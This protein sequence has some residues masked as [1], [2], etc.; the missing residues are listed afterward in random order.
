MRPIW[1]TESLPDW[2]VYWLIPMLSAGQSWPKASESGLW[3][4]REAHRGGLDAYAG[5]FEPTGQALSTISPQWESPAKRPAFTRVGKMYDENV[6]AMS[7]MASRYQY[8]RQA[9]AFA[10]ET[11]YSKISINVAFWVAVIAIAIA[12][13]SAFFSAGTS[14]AAVGPAAAGLRATIAK[15][16]SRLGLAAARPAGVAAAARLTTLAGTS[17]ATRLGSAAVVHELVEEIG[18]EVFIDAYTQYQQI[19]MGTGRAG[20]GKR[21]SRR[22]SGPAP[23]PFVGTKLGTPVSRLHQRDAG[24]R[25]ALNRTAGDLPGWSATRSGDSRGGRSTPV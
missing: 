13:I 14:T 10:L 17:L 9:D 15:I 23:A 19:K 8:A 7:K 16:L 1:E 21:P 4:F 3:R 20:T 6:G 25:A 5:A 22:R 24:H 2:V 18:E 12:L 11:Q